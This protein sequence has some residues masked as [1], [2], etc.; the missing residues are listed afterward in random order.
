MA[1]IAVHPDHWSG[2]RGGVPIP[3]R[4]LSEQPRLSTDTYENRVVARLLDQRIPTHLHRRLRQLR[5]LGQQASQYDTVLEFGA[6]DVRR[7][8]ARLLDEWWASGTATSASDAADRISNRIVALENL[9]DW[10]RG[11]RDTPR[12]FYRQIPKRR[13]VPPVLKRT[14][15]FRGDDRYHRVGQLWDVFGPVPSRTTKERL[16][17]QRMAALGH[18]VFVRSIVLRAATIGLPAYDERRAESQA[19]GRLVLRPPG[20]PPLHVVPL[21]A[22]GEPAAIGPL[23]PPVEADTL[24]VI[25]PPLEDDSPVAWLSPNKRLTVAAQSPRDVLAVESM[26]VWLRGHILGP[27]YT[28]LPPRLAARE[29]DRAALRAAGVAYD[30]VDERRIALR[31]PVAQQRL[32][33]ATSHRLQALRGARL[34]STKRGWASVV[35]AATAASERWTLA[36]VCPAPDCSGEPRIEHVDSTRA[37]LGC[38]EGH[39]WGRERCPSGHDIPF[40]TAHDDQQ[41]LERAGSRSSMTVLGARMLTPVDVTDG[42]LGAHCPTCGKWMPLPVAR[43]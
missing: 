34:E 16:E 41:V 13:R 37:V 7:R 22:E 33:L 20:A 15:V 18:G 25:R 6:H 17:R 42:R 28:E 35:T 1:W 24:V 10:T 19:H 21:F 11:L 23:L 40:V 38:S 12:S 2:R 4:V 26:A 27:I 36:L 14:N 43:T 29:D 32:A 31:G 39:R 30:V 5:E 3:A 9:L 8:I